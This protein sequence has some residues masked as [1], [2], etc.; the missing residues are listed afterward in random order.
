MNLKDLKYL[1]A[2][3]D[4]GHFGKAAARTFVSQPTLSAQ[5]K[6]LEEY[7]GVKLVERQPKNVQLT[8]VGRQIVQ[9][10]RRML[11]Q[12]DEIVALARNNTDPLAGRLKVALIPTVGPYLLPRVMPR[13]RKSLPNLGLMLY[14][15]QTEPLLKRLRDGDID[16]GILALPSDTDG[17]ESRALYEEA[18]LLAV[19]Q[20]HA[21]AEKAQ[22]R[23]QDLKGQ[24]LLLLEDGHCLRDQALEF[25][26]RVD[27]QEV[28]DFRATSL[29]TL[30]QMVIAG[31]GVTLL[32]E[33]AAEAPF[34]SQRGLVTRPFAKPTPS[35]SIGA[36]WRKSSTRTPAIE[37]LCRAV[38][39]GLAR[40]Q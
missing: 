1:V 10:A 38:G 9:R 28:E 14:E 16:V 22:I 2:L 19:P 13:L 40:R 37:E 25:C 39:S 34:G 18:F 3:A 31:L 7:L 30:R 24:A 17:L 32:P 33:L 5:L 6:K 4:T 11:E 35:R 23:V 20:Q 8:E 36:V 27:V 15:Y 21:L 12:G 26:T 29:E